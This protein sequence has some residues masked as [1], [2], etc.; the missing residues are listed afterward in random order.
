CAKSDGPRIPVNTTEAILSIRGDARRETE[1]LITPPTKGAKSEIWGGKTL[2]SCFSKANRR[3]RS[4]HLRPLRLLGD[5]DG[6]SLQRLLR[7]GRTG[8][9]IAK[10]LDRI[11]AKNLSTKKKSLFFSSFRDG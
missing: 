2:R 3:Q 8:G 5:T 7:I 9:T 10:S 1:L 4:I 6:T 11:K